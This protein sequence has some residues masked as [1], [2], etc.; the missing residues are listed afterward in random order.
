MITNERLIQIRWRQQQEELEADTIDESDNPVI[1]VGFGRFGQV[2][3]RLLHA[4]GIG[5]TVLDNDVGHIDMLRKFGYKVFYGDA[6]RLDLLI[7]AGA[8]RARLLI[9][10]V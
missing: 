4:H 3:G 1:I 6:D 5:T 7:A 9:V 8:Q 2:V 10:V